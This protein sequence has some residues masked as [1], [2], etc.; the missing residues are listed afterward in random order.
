MSELASDTLAILE[1]FARQP[2]HDEVKAGFREL[3]VK[4]FGADRSSLNFEERRPIIRGRLDA[5][6]GRT[7]FEAKRN[8][9]REIDD[10]LRRMPDYLSDCER[11]DRQPFVGIASDGRKWM[12]F[13]LVDRQLVKVK[14]TNLDPAKGEQF[15]AWLDGVIALKSSLHPDALTVRAELGQ[16]SVAYRQVDRALRKIWD[17]IGGDPTPAL[18]RQLWADL[19]KLVYGRDVQGDGLWFQHTYLVIVA[20]CIALAVMDL[21]EDDPAR[22]LSGEAFRSAGI[23]GAVESDF[24]DWVLADPEGEALVRRIMAHVRR[25]RLREVESD[26]LKILYESLIDRRASRARRILHSGLA[27]REGR[28]QRRRSTA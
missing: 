16:D 14:E 20:K 10:V 17:R 22:M 12:V 8:L 7:V 9:D 18:K 15:L 3:L 23:E 2:G 21:V 26:V 13:E 6:I 4:E 25:F 5:L 28:P 24:F 11:E 19:L 27:R 1:D